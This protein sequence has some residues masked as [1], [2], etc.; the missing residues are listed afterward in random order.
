MI[1]VRCR[2]CQDPV[3]AAF[4]FM[5]AGV[6]LLHPQP[7][8]TASVAEEEGWTRT[9]RE[10]F[11]REL[12]WRLGLVYLLPGDRYDLVQVRSKS[13]PYPQPWWRKHECAT[14]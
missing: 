11:W 1:F 10:R 3:I 4:H 2:H 14:S 6:T 13:K 9:Q 8:D 7:F 5:H 12:P